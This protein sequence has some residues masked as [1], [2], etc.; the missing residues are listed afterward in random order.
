MAE[1]TTKPAQFRFPKWAH[2]FLAE[3]AS[4]TG[5]SK[6]EVLVEALA[7]Y[8][9]RKLEDLMDEGYREMAEED[10]ADAKA[11]ECTLMDGLRDDPW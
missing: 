7:V 9:R 11:W 8:K 5:T 4:A 10:L 2:E 3:E 1:Y 6:T